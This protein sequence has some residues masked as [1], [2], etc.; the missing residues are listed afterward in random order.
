MAT[1]ARIERGTYSE[2][3]YLQY[4]PPRWVT[5]A[6]AVAG[7]LARPFVWPLAW[8]SRRSDVVFRTVS[9]LLSVI[10][11]AVGIVVRAEF[12]RFALTRCGDNV[13]IEFGAVFVY[14]DVSIGNHVTIN[15]YCIVHHCDFG[16]YVL[17]GEHSVFLS[18]SR[19]HNVDRLDV[20]I[21]LQ[22]GRK[23]R[24]AIGSDCWIGA[25]CVVMEDVAG[26]AVVGAGS[27]VTRPV[28]EYMIAAGNPAKPLRRRGSP[29]AAAAAL[30]DAA[31][32]NGDAR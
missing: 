3:E 11:Y 30:P 4:R 26:G 29:S 9:E 13:V 19:Q 2:V 14:R 12:Y 23:K 22:R 16:D 31:T 15:R 5:V 27:V 21:P 20:P 32:S 25:H 17:V 8:A 7:A 1:P 6:R 10:P 28:P 18:G 24:I